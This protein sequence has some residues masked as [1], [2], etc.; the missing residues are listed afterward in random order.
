MKK[1][2]NSKIAVASL[3]LS[4]LPFVGILAFFAVNTITSRFRIPDLV[5]ITIGGILFVAV[6]LT[7]PAAI[8]TA[9]CGLASVARHPTELKGQGFAS[10][11]LA[12]SVAGI[13][14]AVVARQWGPT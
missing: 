6:F 11:A 2:K 14:L 12:M 7:P 8:I 9:I 5:D 3:A 10:A 4:L 13:V 1:L